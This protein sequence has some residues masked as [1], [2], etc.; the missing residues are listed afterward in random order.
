MLSDLIRSFLGLGDSRLS[1]LSAVEAMRI[2]ID[3]ERPVRACSMETWRRFE[4]VGSVDTRVGID[5]AIR[6]DRYQYQL[7]EFSRSINEI[8]SFP[9]NR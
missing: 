4:D 8:N 2:C 5:G 7:R 6:V 3:S 1:R 9:K